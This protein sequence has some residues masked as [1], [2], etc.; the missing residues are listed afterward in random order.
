ME[1]VKLSMLSKQLEQ[2]KKAARKVD[3]SAMLGCGKRQG[4]F[5]KKKIIGVLFTFILLL[6]LYYQPK[7]EVQAAGTGAFTVEAT[8]GSYTYSNY[9][10]YLNSAGSYH[11]SMPQGAVAT[12]DCIYVNVA[13]GNVNLIIENLNIHTDDGDWYAVSPYMPA[14]GIRYNSAANVTIKIKGSNTLDS[15]FAA[16]GIQKCCSTTNVGNLTLEAVDKDAL[17]KVYSGDGGAGIGGCYGYGTSNITINSGIYDIYGVASGIGGG[18]DHTGQ[19]ITING[20]S[21]NINSFGVSSIEDAYV[22][23]G[24]VKISNGIPLLYNGVEAVYLRKIIGCSGV[25]SVLVDGADY[26]I[27][28]NH[29]GDEAI[30]L[31]LTGKNHTVT[32]TTASG[33]T[34]YLLTWN[35]TDGFTLPAEATP[36]PTPI[37]TTTPVSSTIKSDIAGAVVNGVVDKSYTGSEITQ[38]FTVTYNGK[39]L[40]ENTDYYVYYSDN[41]YPGTATV[42][43]KGKGN[44][45][46][47]QAVTF[48]IL[49]PGLEA[50]TELKAS[51]IERKSVKL[52]WKGVVKADGYQIYRYDKE[53]N[54]YTNVGTENFGGTNSYTVYNLEQDTTYTFVVTAYVYTGNM[55]ESAY[56]FIEVKTLTRPAVNMEKPVLKG[57][58]DIYNIRLEWKNITNAEG[59]FVERRSSD[60]DE[61]LQVGETYS[62]STKTSEYYDNSMEEGTAYQYRVRAYYYDEEDN[63]YTYSSYSNVKKI[64]S[65]LS[66]VWLNIEGKK[67]KAVLKWEEK[68]G[69]DGY[70]IY[71]STK[72]NGKF[73]KIKSITKKSIT[74]YTKNELKSNQYYY[75]KVRSYKKKDGIKIYSEYSSSGAWIL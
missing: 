59:Y 69:V 44:Y 58:A 47:A 71:M 22:R 30:Y 17:L 68:K 3:L 55:I 39:T 40:T 12:K 56:T 41:Y 51:D 67:K 73:K 62:Y 66:S 21:I 1:A 63:L 16:A 46:G 26:N 45:Q 6:F 52:C 48:K 20:G 19:N 74:S 15:C 34:E 60:A 75:F 57:K 38:Q 25:T 13:S 61:F 2:Y 27:K 31:Y 50:V 4:V 35:G 49:A 29:L 64:T 24:T 5:M 18:K 72:N 36:V 9:T 28:N 33:S 10:L 43:I 14:L 23:G 32:V 65:S 7:Q 37:S 8:G 11:I 54:I 42:R 53:S 70:E